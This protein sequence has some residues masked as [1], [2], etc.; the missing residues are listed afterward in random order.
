MTRAEPIERAARALLATLDDVPC[1]V[2]NN[3]P[4]QLDCRCCADLQDLRTALSQ[5]REPAPSHAGAP[6]AS[7]RC[8]KFGVSPGNVTSD[9]RVLHG[10]VECRSISPAA[11][12]PLHPLND[13]RF[14]FIGGD[15]IKPPA[16]PLCPEHAIRLPCPACAGSG[17]EPGRGAG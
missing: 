15:P 8:G 6:D 12:F 7:C 2:C 17:T 13:P 3:G 4:P 9:G 14:A 16:F 1:A 5:P 10:K 11:P